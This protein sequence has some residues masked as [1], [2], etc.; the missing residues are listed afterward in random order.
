MTLNLIIYFLSK[1][2]KKKEK[3]TFIQGKD[4]HV[5]SLELPIQE[6]SSKLYINLQMQQR[7]ANI[8]ERIKINLKQRSKIKINSKLDE[9]E[10]YD[11]SGE[12]MS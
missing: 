10:N 1:R 8:W 7:N 12:I 3:R 4:L 5:C 9:I 2:K 6:L 11:I